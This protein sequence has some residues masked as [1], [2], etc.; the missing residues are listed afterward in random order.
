MTSTTKTLFDLPAHKN[1]VRYTVCASRE[2]LPAQSRCRYRVNV[3]VTWDD[4]VTKHDRIACQTFD[5]AA[6]CDNFALTA[7]ADWLR[8]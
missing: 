6:E 4:G 2:A 1:G 3:D 8:G 5:A 7:T